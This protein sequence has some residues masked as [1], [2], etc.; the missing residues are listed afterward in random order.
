MSDLNK[1]TIDKIA[2]NREDFFYKAIFTQFAHVVR[3]AMNVL[4]LG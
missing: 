3:Q 4:Y 2:N 1:L